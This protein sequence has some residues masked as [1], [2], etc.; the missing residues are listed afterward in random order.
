MYHWKCILQGI[1][2]KLS[3]KLDFYTEAHC[4]ANPFV[5]VLFHTEYMVNIEDVY[6]LN[7]QSL[8]QYTISVEQLI[9]FDRKKYSMSTSY[10][11][12]NRTFLFLDGF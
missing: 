6:W 11:K 7:T 8:A 3:V 10:F 4:C 1:P 2:N 9:D 5:M 12:N